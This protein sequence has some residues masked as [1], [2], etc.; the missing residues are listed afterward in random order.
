M[1]ID[2]FSEIGKYLLDEAKTMASN[3]SPQFMRYRGSFLE[4][5]TKLNHLYEDDLKIIKHYLANYQKIS[6]CFAA[7]IFSTIY[8]NID[9][10]NNLTV[11][12]VN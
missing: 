8:Y 5:A 9:A 11:K 4:I 2:I 3:L 1:E 10:N 7:P 12:I 6:E